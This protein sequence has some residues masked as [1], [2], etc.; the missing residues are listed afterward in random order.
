MKVLKK[1]KLIGRK[2]STN[3]LMNQQKRKLLKQCQEN[4]RI[5]Q[6]FIDD[7]TFALECLTLYPHLYTKFSSTVKSDKE[8]CLRTLHSY[9]DVYKDLPDTIKSERSVSLFAFSYSPLNLKH[10]PEIFRKEKSF[11][12]EGLQYKVDSQCKEEITP[13]FFHTESLFLSL[14]YTLQ[15]DMSLLKLLLKVYPRDYQ[16]ISNDL[17]QSRLL[18]FITLKASENGQEF[19][20]FSSDFKKDK[21]VVSLALEKDPTLFEFADTSLKLDQEYVLQELKKSS[22]ILSCTPLKR[23]RDFMKMVIKKW[24]QPLLEFL[25]FEDRDLFLEIIQKNPHEILLKEG[26]YALDN[27]ILLYKNDYAIM[28]IIV[29]KLPKK[30]ELLADSLK[31][32]PNFFID[33][34]KLNKTIYKFFP[35]H[36]KEDIQVLSFLKRISMNQIMKMNKV[37]DINF[38]FD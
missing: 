2:I 21:E 11:I 37:L 16:Y 1:K 36:M 38:Q 27:L 7:R 31:F 18:C 12:M 9:T 32:N 20:L 34:L 33:L 4:G 10:L 23:D 35:K 29:T 13:F 15:N 24:N 22:K 26:E 6:E 14:D 28:Q 5:P 3:Y 17:K 19:K 25:E 8:I 30:H